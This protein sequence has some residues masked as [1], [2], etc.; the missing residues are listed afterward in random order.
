MSK[1]LQ[2]DEG[3]DVELADAVRPTTLILGDEFSGA[4]IKLLES[5]KVEVRVC[6]YAWRWYENE[7]ESEIQRVNTAIYAL[8]GRAVRFR[9]IVDSLYTRDWLFALGFEVRCVE[10]NRTLHTKAIGVDDTG[11]L[12]GSHNLTKRATRDNLE[13]S[14]LVH[15]T[16]TVIEYNDYFDKLWDAY[17]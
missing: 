4:A 5:A 2:T 1:T 13:A 6:A 14:V 10:S 11:L 9:A 15:D 16:T 17:G 8:R 12:I 7:P 3:R